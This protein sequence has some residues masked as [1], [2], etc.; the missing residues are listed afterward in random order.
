MRSITE[1]WQQSSPSSA[2]RFSPECA[3]GRFRRRSAHL[4]SDTT[5]SAVDARRCA[6][7]P[8]EVALC[9]STFRK[10]HLWKSNLDIWHVWKIIRKQFLISRC[11]L[12]TL[13]KEKGK[14]TSDLGMIS[15]STLTYVRVAL[16]A[17]F[18]KKI[19]SLAKRIMPYC[20][21]FAVTDI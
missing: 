11:R 7:L 3:L 10:F 14:Q 20:W 5:V 6:P 1:H 15:V 16:D 8:P 2:A 12:S 13:M 19:R 18:E 17:N 21:R 9:P 4:H